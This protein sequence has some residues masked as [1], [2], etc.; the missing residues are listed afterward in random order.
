MY[1]IYVL[2]QHNL[3]RRDH[4]YLESSKDNRFAEDYSQILLLLSSILSSSCLHL[5]CCCSVV[6][7][8]GHI[9]V[10]YQKLKM[11]LFLFPFFDVLLRFV[12]MP[13]KSLWCIL[14]A[15]FPNGRGYQKGCFHAN[16]NHTVHF[17]IIRTWWPF[18]KIYIN[19]YFKILVTRIMFTH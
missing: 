3:M 16:S 1:Y 11:C 18:V 9:Q 10:L 19:Y 6:V 4:C 7:I 2:G 15:I 13:Y 5:L 8:V 17:R 12:M 14:Y